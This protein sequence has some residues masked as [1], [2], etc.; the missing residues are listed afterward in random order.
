MSVIK[1]GVQGKY[2]TTPK[3]CARSKK[4]QS[5]HKTI[6]DEKTQLHERNRRNKYL[7]NLTI[8]ELKTEC[9]LRRLG[10]GMA[11]S[12]VERSS[13]R[14]KAGSNGMAFPPADTN[15]ERVDQAGGNNLVLWRNPIKTFK[16]TI[17]EVTLLLQL[18]GNRLLLQ[19]KLLT[20]IAILLITALVFCYL[21]GSHQYFITLIKAK[22]LHIIYWTGL[23][24]LSSVGFGTGLHTFLLYLGPHIASVTLAAYECNTLNFPEPP[25]P[26]EILCPDE[27]KSIISPSMWSIMSKVR[28]EA[29]LW[30]VGTALGELPPYF[31]ARASRL[32]GTEDREQ[33]F[34]EIEELQKR[35]THGEKLSLFERGKL[36]M[37][38]FVEKVGFF[39][40]LLCASIPNPLFDLAG[41]TC[42]HFLV[43]FWTFF[44]AT[45]IGKAIV[46]MHIQKM[47]V[48]IAFNE[49][50]VEKAVD[51]LQIIPFIGKTLQ[52]PF[53]A[54]LQNQKDRLHRETDKLSR[55]SSN[56]I[57][58]LFEY[59]VISM[60]CF[61]ILSIINSLAQ[62]Y[63]K[64]LQSAKKK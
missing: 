29:F 53:K 19:R 16:Y 8:D 31:M 14:R 43:P 45:L 48:I 24:I 56:M 20:S 13:K 10:H 50:L 6:D 4:L 60:V 40:I 38:K 59:F 41:I 58:N 52:E 30:G 3:N 25:Y 62:N 51:L 5:V 36:A 64:R 7:N 18:Y 44:G 2:L 49:N 23:G 34:R 55:N 35:K 63:A 17:L 12:K 1:E 47:F 21:P 33:E 46:K 28:L 15:D 11:Q 32:S 54:F 22:S 39:G 37:E 26:N 57:Q 42:G 61:F 27:M 9:Q